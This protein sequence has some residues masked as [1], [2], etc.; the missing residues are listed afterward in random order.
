MSEA[1]KIGDYAADSLTGKVVKMGCAYGTLNNAGLCFQISGANYQVTAG[2]TLTITGIVFIGQAS[3]GEGEMRY[4]NDAALTNTPISLC[5]LQGTLLTAPI[6]IVFPV[7]RTVP[8]G[9]FVGIF[10]ANNC[11]GTSVIMIGYEA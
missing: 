8:A 7:H 4:A 2:K 9:K 1:F 3:A 5:S 11:N 10:S 6:P